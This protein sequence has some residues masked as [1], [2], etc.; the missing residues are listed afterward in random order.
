MRLSWL[1]R[2]FALDFLEQ[3]FRQNQN[4]R[5]T[6]DDRIFD[7]ILYIFDAIDLLR[8]TV[9]WIPQ[10]APELCISQVSFS[11]SIVLLRF[12]PFGMDPFFCATLDM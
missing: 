2:S 3:L 11:L 4:R 1:E 7:F 9:V 10:V 12:F 8:H 5:L 6:R